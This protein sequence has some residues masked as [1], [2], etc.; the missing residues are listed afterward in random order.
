MIGALQD[1]WEE[2]K[3]FSEIDKSMQDDQ[4]SNI[5]NLNHLFV[6]LSATREVV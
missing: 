1:N 3:A 2:T 4:S 6:R 5:F